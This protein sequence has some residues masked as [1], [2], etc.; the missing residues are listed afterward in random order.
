MLGG[1][2]VNH[3]DIVV[4]ITVDIGKIYAYRGTA[5]MAQS[6]WVD[7][8]K[9]ALSG[10]DLNSIRGNIVVADVQIGRFIAVEVAEHDC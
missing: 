8:A 4:S 9:R 10:I 1:Q 3:H 2:H 5:G 7:E 6:K